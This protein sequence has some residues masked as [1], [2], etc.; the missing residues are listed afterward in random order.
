MRLMDRLLDNSNLQKRK[1]L[2]RWEA[3]TQKSGDAG[4]IKNVELS[5][6]IALICFD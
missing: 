6:D 2:D 3:K 5:R 4:R 1:E